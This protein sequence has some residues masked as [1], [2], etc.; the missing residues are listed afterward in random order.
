M[1]WTN[2]GEDHSELTKDWSLETWQVNISFKCGQWWMAINIPATAPQ[3]LTHNSE[4]RKALPTTVFWISYWVAQANRRLL[5][6]LLQK[7]QCAHRSVAWNTCY[8]PCYHSETRKSTNR[9]LQQAYVYS[10]TSLKYC[11]G[12]K[13]IKAIVED[14]KALWYKSHGGNFGGPSGQQVAESLEKVQWGCSGAAAA[15]V[16]RPG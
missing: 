6:F 14:P 10:S 13:G 11:A 16:T 5:T 4:I 2:C 3:S 8:V 1:I 15:L 9:K 7:Y 12:R